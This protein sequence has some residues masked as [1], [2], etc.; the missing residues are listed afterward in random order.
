[1]TKSERRTASDNDEARPG[2][3]VRHH[4]ESC[5]LE[6]SRCNSSSAS[7]PIVGGLEHGRRPTSASLGALLL[8]YFPQIHL[9][10]E[11]VE[12][13][14]EKECVAQVQEEERLRESVAVALAERDY[15]MH[16]GQTELSHLDARDPRLEDVQALLD[17]ERGRECRH[18]VIGIHESVD[19]RVH[20]RKPSVAA[21]GRELESQPD[22]KRHD[23]VVDHVQAAHMRKLLAQDHEDGIGEFDDLG[24]EEEPTNEEK[25]TRR[26]IVTR[27]V[28]IRASPR[29]E[30]EVEVT[31]AFVEHPSR[32]EDH[33]EIVA[34]HHVFEVE[35]LAIL[36]HL[37]SVDLDEPQ[38]DRDR[39]HRGPR[40]GAHHG[41]VRNATVALLIPEVVDVIMGRG[42][43][44]L[45]KRRSR[46]VHI[47]E[48]HCG[49]R[50]GRRVN[51]MEEV[52]RPFWPR[53]RELKTETASRPRRD[54]YFYLGRQ[55]FEGYGAR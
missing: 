39:R 34:D 30:A 2:G 31:G 38:V 49:A 10:I 23:A 41:K 53:T 33:D 47:D 28:H 43:Q 9:A 42:A 44:L 22:G 24:E 52:H 11:V 35:R 6:V 48:R 51:S 8:E 4:H 17:A 7:R 18:S 40:A 20:E 27:I 50:F 36:H 54:L 15:A 29:V 5:V 46:A 25:S 16:D 19:E 13:P 45:E 37:R 14:Q 21:S 26:R 12:K 32:Y 55:K 1:M 3:L